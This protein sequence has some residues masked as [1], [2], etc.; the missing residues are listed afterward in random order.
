MEMKIMLAGAVV[1][2]GFLWAYL[3]VRQF[4]FN[5]R[6]AYPIIR[7]MNS[8]QPDL[9]S[10]GAVRYTR[11]SDLVTIGVGGALLAGIIYLCRNNLLMLIS[12]AIGAVFAI[13]FIVMRCKPSNKEMFD[14]FSNA[15]SR[16]IPD[17]E[18]RTIMYNKEYEKVKARLKNMGIRETFLPDFKKKSA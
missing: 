8:L 15:Y 1:L 2:G 18:L 3:F 11:I 5:V 4:I 17:D 14:L 16:F 6:V 13:V 10:I 12:F 9:I 7:K